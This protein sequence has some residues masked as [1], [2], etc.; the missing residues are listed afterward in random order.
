MEKNK[1]ESLFKDACSN[2]LINLPHFCKCNLQVMQ[3]TEATYNNILYSELINSE[4]TFIPV[5]AL[6]KL[7]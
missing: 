3:P 1:K 4:S 5:S 6:S 2:S 7:R